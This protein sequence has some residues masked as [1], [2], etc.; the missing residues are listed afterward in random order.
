M[1]PAIITLDS[2][3]I[4]L[5]VNSGRREGKNIPP[6]QVYGSNSPPENLHGHNSLQCVQC[7]QYG[8]QFMGITVGG[9][10]R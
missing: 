9:V 6:V 3:W 2:D 7:G 10:S 1:L 8:V 5:D 4:Q